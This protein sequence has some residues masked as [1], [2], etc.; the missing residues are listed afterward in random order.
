MQITFEIEDDVVE[1]MLGTVGWGP[2]ELAETETSPQEALE[3]LLRALAN[4]MAGKS[5]EATAGL[6]LDTE[7]LREELIRITSAQRPIEADISPTVRGV[8]YQ[9]WTPDTN[10]QTLD[11]SPAR[12]PELEDHI[13][14]AFE[15]MEVSPKL[16]TLISR[17]RDA[18]NEVVQE[19]V[20]ADILETLEFKVHMRGATY[21][22]HISPVGAMVIGSLD[23]LPQIVRG[24]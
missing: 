10:W 7:A 21:R 19:G 18:T 1:A 5:D 3:L 2:Q 6:D 4:V 8:P 9:V 13:A 23:G 24:R 14:S 12:Y 20:F 22:C 16:R 17:R 15:I 11:S